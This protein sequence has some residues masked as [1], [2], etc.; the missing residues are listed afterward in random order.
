VIALGALSFGIVALSR[1]ENVNAAWLV[2]AAVCIYFIGCRFYV[3]KIGKR[4]RRDSRSA[5]AVN[6]L[7]QLV[8]DEFLFTDYAFYQISNRYNSDQFA[9]I[10]NGKVANSLLSHNGHAFFHSLI[11]VSV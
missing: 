7:Y 11:K 4:D 5:L 2:I 3:L 1:G 6:K 8:N 9:L 10:N